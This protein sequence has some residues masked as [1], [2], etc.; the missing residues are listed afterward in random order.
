MTCLSVVLCKGWNCAILLQINK[1]SA[2]VFPRTCRYANSATVLQL[3]HSE[4]L[5]VVFHLK[6]RSQ[7]E[8]KSCT[9]MKSLSSQQIIFPL[10][11]I[12]PSL[13]PFSLFLYFLPLFSFFPFP[14]F[15]LYV[16][17]ILMHF[18]LPFVKV[19]KSECKLSFILND[20][21]DSLIFYCPCTLHTDFSNRECQ[22]F[23]LSE[24]SSIKL[25]LEDI[26]ENIEV[27]RGMQTTTESA[28]LS[29]T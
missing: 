24:F 16:T 22:H 8:R 4:G 25:T 7:R 2:V 17:I 23:H 15:L 10:P 12:P 29:T 21:L 26:K 13:S 20:Q 5:T 18:L 6:E 27:E 28:A 3:C 11:A 19:L 1:S 9:E 14:T